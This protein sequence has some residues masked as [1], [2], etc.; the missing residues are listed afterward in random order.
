MFHGGW[1]HMKEAT[2]YRLGFSMTMHETQE[3]AALQALCLIAVMRPS[4]DLAAT[5]QS[6][7]TG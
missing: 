2:G 4:E 6:R 3:G 1:L 5:V 7:T